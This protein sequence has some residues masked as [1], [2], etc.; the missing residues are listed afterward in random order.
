[1]VRMYPEDPGATASST[2]AKEVDATLVR[3]RSRL[4]ATLIRCGVG[5]AYAG[6][7]GLRASSAE[8]GAAAAVARTSGRPNT[9]VP[10]DSVGLGGRSSSGTR[11]TRPRTPWARCSRL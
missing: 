2:V 3:V 1:L 7:D 4:P 5:S 8:A 11:P 6:A 9:A 10:F